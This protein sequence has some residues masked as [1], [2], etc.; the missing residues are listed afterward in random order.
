MNYPFATITLLL[1]AGLAQA[2]ERCAEKEAQI[3]RQ[4]EHAQA[5][6]NAGRVRGLKI[7]LEN[8]QASCTEAG[9]EAERQA[10]IEDARDE[11]AERE[12]DLRE[13]QEDGSPKKI[14]RREHKLVEAQD[15]L[16][17]AQAE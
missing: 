11:V 2:Q 10:K 3:T 1:V 5:D 4:L 17:D 9:L 7:A 15:E 8:V 12:A 6:G 16:R 13:A 14:E